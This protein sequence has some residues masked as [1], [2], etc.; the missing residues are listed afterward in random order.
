MA[1]DMGICVTGND[2]HGDKPNSIMGNPHGAAPGNIP[3]VGELPAGSPR[4]STGD[5]RPQGFFGRS[6]VYFPGW[7][8][9]RAESVMPT[10]EERKR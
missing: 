8:G 3:C 7:A 2:R 10:R 1:R 4:A 5:W 9:L 6:A